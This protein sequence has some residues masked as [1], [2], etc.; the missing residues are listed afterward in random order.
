MSKKE[1][2]AA[3]AVDFAGY[4]GARDA[5]D[6]ALAKIRAVRA[7]AASA[8]EIIATQEPLVKAAMTEAGG[9][10]VVGDTLLEFTKGNQ[11]RITT[12]ARV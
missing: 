10:L 6:N 3:V 11:V 4:T 5:S 1:A 9:R 2:K 7:E 12:V 8:K